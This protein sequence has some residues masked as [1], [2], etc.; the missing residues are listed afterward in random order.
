MMAIINI[1]PNNFKARKSY[2]QNKNYQPKITTNNKNV[3]N[4]LKIK[5][6]SKTW[7]PKEKYYDA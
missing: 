2:T 1:Y 7:V 3:R 6:C 5:N 4:L